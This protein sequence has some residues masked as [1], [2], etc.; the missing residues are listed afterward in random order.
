[1]IHLLEKHGVRVYSLAEE[2]REV[3]A[4]SFWIDEANPFVFLNTMKSAEHSRMDSA[5]E[6]GHLVLHRGHDA[7]R[8]REAEYEAK[9]FASAFLMPR[10]SVLAAAP[11]GASLAQ[12]LRLKGH[13]GVSV[14]ALTYRMHRLGLLSDWQYRAMFIEIGKRGYRTTEPNAMDRETSQV[15]VKVFNSLRDEGVSKADVANALHIPLDELNKSIFGLVF[16][17]V[18][19]GGSGKDAHPRPRTLRLVETG[20][21]DV[22]V[23]G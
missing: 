6:L 23:D 15:L 11:A 5:H 19:G 18:P 7:P 16:T 10:G 20:I 1:M 4:F 3:D 21:S 13:W 14:A 22:E 8:G 2:C 17:K 12:L 9:L